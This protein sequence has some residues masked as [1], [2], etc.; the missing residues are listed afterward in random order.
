METFLQQEERIDNYK[1]EINFT[2]EGRTV[3][4]TVDLELRAR[5]SM[6]EERVNGQEDSVMTEMIKLLPQEKSG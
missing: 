2:E 6:A 4:I 5:T 1:K 3:E